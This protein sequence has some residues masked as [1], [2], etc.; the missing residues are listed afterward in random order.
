[1]GQVMT[2]LEEFGARSRIGLEDDR[3]SLAHL[4][5]VR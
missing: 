4:A 2:V 3:Q 5:K 1:V